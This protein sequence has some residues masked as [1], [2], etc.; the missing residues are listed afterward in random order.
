[1][2]V[3]PLPASNTK[4]YFILVNADGLNHSMQIRVADTVSDAAAVTN[5]GNFVDLLLNT[6][7]QSVS[8]NGLEVA[9]K[10]SDIRNAVSGWTTK[11]GLGAAN[12]PDQD[13][14]LTLCA[15]GR[16]STGRKVKLF[17]WGQD[18]TRTP[19]WKL[20]PT[21]ESD[22]EVAVQSLNSAAEYFLAIDGNKPV[23]KD[24]LT[25]DF[26]DHYEQQARG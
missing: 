15:R 8:Y 6:S 18:F 4:R 9:Q 16:S 12:M 5:L 25:I 7:F 14:P 13:R 26:N 20:V 17:I 19:N 11:T 23:W 21:A 2:A 22:F 1:M 3:T 10:G 24:D